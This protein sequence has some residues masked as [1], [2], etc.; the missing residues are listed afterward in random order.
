MAN[1]LLIFLLVSIIP[2]SVP[3]YLRDQSTIPDNKSANLTREADGDTSNQPNYRYT[4]QLAARIGENI[5]VFLKGLIPSLQ[6]KVDFLA[7]AITDA[8]DAT[9]NRLM[10]KLENTNNTIVGMESFFSNMYETL[11]VNA[12]GGKGAF[13]PSRLNQRKR[14]QVWSVVDQLRYKKT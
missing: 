2:L 1:H 10:Q 8:I 3:L 13:L 7:D 9:N 11:I 6:P 4:S 14:R 12:N 5:I